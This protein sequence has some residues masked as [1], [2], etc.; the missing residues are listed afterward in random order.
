MSQILPLEPA[1]YRAK[2]TM[3]DFLLLDGHGAFAGHRKTELIDGDIYVVNAQYRP[4]GMVKTKLYDAL[5]DA[6][7]T[8]GSPFRPVQEFSLA[9]SNISTPEPDVMLT[10]DPE[11]SGLVP[12][13]SVALVIEVSDA[14]LEMDL[15]RKAA[16]Y[17]EAGIPEYWVADVNGRKV[18]QHWNPVGSRYAEQRD[19]SFGE[20]IAA[21]SFQGLTIGTTDL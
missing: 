17:A 2:L 5:R 15:G 14:T 19:V 1:Q 6:L 11:G 3:R 18:R 13:K 8:M 12:L 9:L 16:I 21:R 7:R 4:H 10:D 20:P